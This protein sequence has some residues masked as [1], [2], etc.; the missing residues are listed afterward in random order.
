LTTQ[1]VDSCQLEYTV[2]ASRGL[3]RS[4]CRV[5]SCSARSTVGRVIQIR[6]SR[7]VVVV[8]KNPTAI[9]G[10]FQTK[11]AR[12]LLRYSDAVVFTQLVIAEAYFLV[13][14]IRSAD[15]DRR[16]SKTTIHTD[17]PCPV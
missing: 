11:P 15:D 3:H 7:A 2:Q 8:S 9:G 6:V 5:V 1:E 17:R 12:Q 16:R 4:F 13:K 14:R 10:S